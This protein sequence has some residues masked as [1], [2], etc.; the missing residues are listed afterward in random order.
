VCAF[1]FDTA[2]TPL[3]LALGTQKIALD[4]LR[5]WSN[6]VAG[7]FTAAN[8]ARQRLDEVR[9]AQPQDATAIA[10]AEA[11]VKKK[12]H[13]AAVAKH[14]AAVA[15]HEAAVAKHE[16]AVAKHEAA[17][18]Q[19]GEGSPEYNSAA[20]AKLKAAVAEHQAAV[21]MHKA[22]MVVYVEGTAQYIEAERQCGRATNML[23]TAECDLDAQ[24]GETLV[25]FS[26]CSD[27]LPF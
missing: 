25:A 3:S 26:T 17:M 19:H 7:A 12:E 20:L 10:L 15:K 18:A 14:E 9:S 22:E 5:I 11:D 8:A 27:P 2:P 24:A 16:A 4:N 21:A 13:E 1:L 23:H 6:A